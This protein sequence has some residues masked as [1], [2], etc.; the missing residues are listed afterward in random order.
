MLHLST[1]AA[2]EPSRPRGPAARRAAPLATDAQVLIAGT[3]TSRVTLDMLSRALSTSPFRLC[4][5]F[6][7]ATGST[8]HQHLTRLRLAAALEQLP[9][10]RDRLAD[11]ALELG[12]SSHSHFTSAFRS[13][14]GRAPSALLDLA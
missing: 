14:F 5:A 4:R 6:R 1:G 12:L 3:C 11:L 8:V 2:E 7:Q 10:Y 13:Y 9:R